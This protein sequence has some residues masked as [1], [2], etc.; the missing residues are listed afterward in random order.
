[1]IYARVK[2][3]V[4]QVPTLRRYVIAAWRMYHPRVARART[5]CLQ[6][7]N[8]KRFARERSGD[9]FRPKQRRNGGGDDDISRTRNKDISRGRKRD[10]RRV[11]RPAK[12]ATVTNNN[13]V[14]IKQPAK[15]RRD[16]REER[17]GERRRERER[18][19][20]RPA[21]LIPRVE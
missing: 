16:A 6:S 17:E 10:G 3:D 9:P 15:G 14:L 11:A 8:K 12:S 7:G 13:K 20:E 1:L 21:R 2:F 18:E 5:R 19:R 4:L